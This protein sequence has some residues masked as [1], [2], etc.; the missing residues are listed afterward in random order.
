MCVC[1]CIYVYV[2]AY[3]MR[4]LCIYEYM[5]ESKKY[6]TIYIYI[7]YV[8]IQGI[9]NLI[10]CQNRYLYLKDVLPRNRSLGIPGENP[11]MNLPKGRQW[12]QDAGDFPPT[13]LRPF[14]VN[15]C[16]SDRGHI[17]YKSQNTIYHL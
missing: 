1:V 8:C 5:K 17:I 2:Y 6:N 3:K 11:E 15:G 16:G 12:Q 4:F 7:Q 13:K 14:A 10:W 9:I